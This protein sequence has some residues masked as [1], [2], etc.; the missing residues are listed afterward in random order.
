MIRMV[1]QFLVSLA[2]SALAFLVAGWLI[3]GFQLQ[4]SGFVVAV[5]VFTAAQTLLGPFIFNLGRKHAPA[6]MGG[7]GLVSTLVALVIASL[8]SGGLRIEGVTTWFIAALTVWFVTALAGWILLAVL[9]R[10]AA[11]QQRSRDDEAALRRLAR[12][13][14]KD[15][16]PTAS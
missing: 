12:K 7:I 11:G 9:A 5:V 6:L 3:P 15:S 14:G 2:S 4:T 10:R 1:S 16:G 8:F 13:S